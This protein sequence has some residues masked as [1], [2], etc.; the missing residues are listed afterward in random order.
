MLL[1]WNFDNDNLI[2]ERPRR[3]LY[4][5]FESVTTKPQSLEMPAPN[6]K[7]TYFRYTIFVPNDGGRLFLSKIIHKLL[8]FSK[9]SV[10]LCAGS[11]LVSAR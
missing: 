1:D 4:I 9:S 5:W 11:G 3:D 8:L 10:Q 7:F 2:T 6:L